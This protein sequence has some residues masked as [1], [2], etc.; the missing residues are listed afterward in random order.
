MANPKNEVNPPSNFCTFYWGG[1]PQ[2]L[3]QP[4]LEPTPYLK[5][6]TPTLSLFI[7]YFFPRMAFFEHGGPSRGRW[8]K[9]S[10]A[11]GLGGGVKRA[12]PVGSGRD[13][14]IP[15]S[16]KPPHANFQLVIREFSLFDPCHMAWAIREVLL[17]RQL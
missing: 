9:V 8:D 7:I 15:R 5:G 17:S 13:R 11:M 16:R 4:L 1:L 2:G 10:A 14:N 3:N 12:K 6:T